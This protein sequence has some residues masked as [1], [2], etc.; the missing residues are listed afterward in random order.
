MD[1]IRRAVVHLTL[2]LCVTWATSAAAQQDHLKCY[3]IKDS[4]A[5]AS[6]T[7]NV[8][9]LAP[10]NGCV[11]KVP[12]KLLCVAATKSNVTPT[13]PGGGANDPAN[14][15]I[16][17]KLKCPKGTLAPINIS[18][19]FGTRSAQPGTAKMLCAPIEPTT[20]TTTAPTTSTTTTTL[21][22]LKGALTPTLGRFNYNLTLGLPG[23][24]AACN[25]NFP[26]THA[27]TYQEL[28]TAQAAGDLDGLKDIAAATVTSFWAIDPLAPIL[29]QCNDDQIG[30]SDLNWEYGTADTP[31]RGQRVS[32]NNPAGTLGAL[33]SSVQ[34]N[35]AGTS[36]VGCCL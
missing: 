20:T 18:D 21:T 8:N 27:C 34:C 3:K 24:N 33:Q 31:S 12:G 14:S 2:A 15:F 36:W 13:P 16:C 35:I 29:Q 22:E 23:A 25:T 1:S 10:E 28:Q 5:K 7:A 32:L 30:G 26:G 17:Y 11:I 9:G 6:Y 4:Q 19:Q